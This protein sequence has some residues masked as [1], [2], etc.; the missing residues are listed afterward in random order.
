V[1]EYALGDELELQL[2]WLLITQVIPLQQVDM[3]V[4]GAMVVVKFA[5]FYTTSWKAET[6]APGDR[7]QR[8]YLHA[9]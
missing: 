5:T 4:S 8:R 1:G 9:W 6:F 2:G 7:C 3:A